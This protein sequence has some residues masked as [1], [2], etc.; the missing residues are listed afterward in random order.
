M[1]QLNVGTCTIQAG[2]TINKNKWK[3]RAGLIHLS[4]DVAQQADDL[5]QVEERAQ[6]LALA[7]QSIR[8]GHSFV[9]K[10]HVPN[11]VMCTT[12]NS[13]SQPPQTHPQPHTKAQHA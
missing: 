10:T 6:S 5:R 12:A 9:R 2:L 7:A 4:R 8:L 3:R 11:S 1:H 13:D